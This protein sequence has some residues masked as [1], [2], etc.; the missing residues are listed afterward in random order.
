[1]EMLLSGLSRLLALALFVFTAFP[2]VAQS[3]K[4]TGNCSP[5]VTGVG[6]DVTI[7]CVTTPRKETIPSIQGLFS[8]WDENKDF[9]KVNDFIINHER[10][11]IYIDL[12]LSAN[13]VDTFQSVNEFG[14][15]AR[16]SL[17]NEKDL[18]EK[19]T[20]GY[21]LVALNDVEARKILGWRSG[22]VRLSGYFIPQVLGVNFGQITTSLTQVSASDVLLRN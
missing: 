8:D 21:V 13:L 1:M 20:Y 11:I 2:V 10:K 9:S 14:Q 16:I 7:S 17:Y 4:S 12:Y 5:N 15:F 3:Q 18:Q 6:G 22:S 19:T